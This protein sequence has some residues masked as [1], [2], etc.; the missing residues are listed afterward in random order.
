MNA[1]VIMSLSPRAGGNCDRAAALF[2][3]SLTGKC[4]VVHLRDHDV[5]GCTG[6][7]ICSLDGVCRMSGED[8]AED[9]FAQLDLAGGLVLTAPVYFYHLPSQAKAW[10][11][12]AQSRYLA[13]LNGLAVPGSV[14][15]AYLVLVAGRAQGELLFS[16]I[17]PTMRYFLDTLDFSIA[18]TL[19]LRGLDET[20]AFLRDRA[21]QDSVRKLA[22]E[23]GW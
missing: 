22:E 18:G 17:M 7:G 14:R 20:G 12:R 13:R 5:Q 9:L 19:K 1:P 2:A 3:Q 23:S 10:I 15:A 16:G 4:E 6:C 21:A 8:A 11:D